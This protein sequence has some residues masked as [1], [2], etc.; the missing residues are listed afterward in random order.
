MYI[1][2]GIV[3]HGGAARVQPDISVPEVRCSPGT[4]RTLD[5]LIRPNCKIKHKEI[6]TYHEMFA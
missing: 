6:N 3:I 5:L 4:L 2:S 1:P